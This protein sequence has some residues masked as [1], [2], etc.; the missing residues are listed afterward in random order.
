M[1]R[2]HMDAAVR[3]AWRAH[4][5]VAPNPT[6]GCAIVAPNGERIALAAHQR[7]GGPHAERLALDAAGPAARGAT[8]VVTL[9][10]CDHVGRQPACSGGLIEAGI[11][12]VVYAVADPNPLAAGGAAS[13]RAA[14]IACDPWTAHTGARH[15]AARFVHR[16]TTGRPWVTVK[17][18]TTIDGA[19]AARTGHSQWISGAQ[20]R[21][22]VHR[23]RGRVDAI[24]T[25][26]GTILADDA[27]LTPRHV[28]VRR[29]PHRVVVDPRFRT[30]P[31]GRLLR[32]SG[33]AAGPVLIAGAASRLKAG[34]PAIDALRAAGAE[35]LGLPDV[36][37][38]GTGTGAGAGV[39]FGTGTGARGGADALAAVAGRDVHPHIDLGGLLEQLA[40]R[41]MSEVLVEAGG[42]VAGG[43]LAGGHVQELWTFT[44]PPIL[45]DAEAMRPAAGASVATID[46]AARGE[47]VSVHRRGGDVMTRWYLPSTAS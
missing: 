13:L 23:E 34:G 24:L 16:I 36:P 46:A 9:E 15:L 37:R 7:N 38:A 32:A 3:A 30:P 19:I 39:G 5:H 33:P 35:L 20:S 4:G 27:E 47:L 2:P 41:G 28:P 40:G 26:I 45:G 31:G 21:R 14:A 12:R 18:A 11:A 1:L 8:A 25:G 22:L 43:L 44:G 42:G 6:V 10:P 17:W 29:V